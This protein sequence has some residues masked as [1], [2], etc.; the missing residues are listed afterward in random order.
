MAAEGKPDL[1]T[2][3]ALGV[4]RPTPALDR[5]QPGLPLEKGR[6]GIFTPEYGRHGTAT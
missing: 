6:C 1:E 4:N 3:G 2:A 5:T